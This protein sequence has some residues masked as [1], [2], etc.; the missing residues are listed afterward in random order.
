MQSD[1]P[2]AN[3]GWLHGGEKHRLKCPVAH[4]TAKR[5][6][7]P[8][9]NADGW[10]R[11]VRRILTPA[12]LDPWAAA[13]GLT[14]DTLFLMGACTLGEMLAFPMYDG[15]GA[16]CGIRTRYPDGRKMSVRGSRAGVFLPFMSIDTIRTARRQVYGNH[17]P[18]TQEPQQ[19]RGFPPP[20]GQNAPV[21]LGEAEPLI[22][23]G[24]TDATA[25]MDLGFYPIG[26]PS[27]QGCEKHVLDT[28]RRMHFTRATI[29]SDADGPGITGARKLADGLR[30]SRI[31]V[32]IV[33]PDGH[34]DLRDWYRHGATRDVVETAWSQA[35]WR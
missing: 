16:I 30:A 35:E 6:E 18:D 26:R 32:R 29:C 2:L 7:D 8:D 23:E 33:K 21:R 1:H 3:G 20:P 19:K 27:C 14:R 25:A 15:A 31:A 34:K 10:W 17:T 28:C 24:P 11:A 5:Y 12:K 13:L 9:F 22:C 4:Q